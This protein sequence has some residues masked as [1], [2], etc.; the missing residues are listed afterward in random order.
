MSQSDDFSPGVG[1]DDMEAAFGTVVITGA[2]SV[3]GMACARYFAHEG[4]DLLLI[5]R[6]RRRLNEQADDLTTRTLRNVDVWEA[7]LGQ[8]TELVPLIEKIR[9][10]ASVLAVICAHETLASHKCVSARN[11]G[12]PSDLF[13]CSV[14]DYLKERWGEALSTRALV[15]IIA[16]NR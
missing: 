6:D 7:D 3:L 16:G 1:G 8:L 11:G 4:Y 12:S 14:A 15:T 10:H 13:M 9:Q 2:S 5:D